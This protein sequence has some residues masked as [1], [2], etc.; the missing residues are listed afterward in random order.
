M[1]NLFQQKKNA[2][3]RFRCVFRKYYLHRQL[4]FGHFFQ[5]ANE[6]GNMF[7]WASLGTL[8]NQKEQENTIVI[9]VTVSTPNDVA[10]LLFN[11]ESIEKFTV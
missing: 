3:K 5:C 8:P 4:F 7:P 9:P 11:R 1:R 6:T 2:H 10:L